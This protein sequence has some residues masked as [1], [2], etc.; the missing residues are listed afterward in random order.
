[1]QCVDLY[2]CKSQLFYQQNG[3]IWEYQRDC[4]SGQGS[5]GLV[6]QEIKKEEQD[7]VRKKREL[8]GA[9]LNENSL[10]ESEFR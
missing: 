3:L 6:N 9:A 4:H 2:D 10:E 5:W 1:M 8:G 7:F